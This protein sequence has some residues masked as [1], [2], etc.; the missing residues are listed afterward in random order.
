MCS[1]LPSPPPVRNKD[2]GPRVA[3]IILGGTLGTVVAIVLC[4]IFWCCICNKDS[5][6]SDID[7]EKDRKIVAVKEVDDFVEL[8]T[9]DD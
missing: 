9:L 6:S 3:Y 8:A 7:K 4:T 2:T 5:E 1:P